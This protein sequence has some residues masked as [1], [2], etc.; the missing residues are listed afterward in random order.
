MCQFGFAIKDT[1]DMKAQDLES[2]PCTYETPKNCCPLHSFLDRGA[3]EVLQKR[4][5]FY[6]AW[7]FSF[8]STFERVYL[9]LMVTYVTYGTPS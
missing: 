9:I 2:Q 6:S 1:L 7:H 8:N 4:N 3:T 5:G